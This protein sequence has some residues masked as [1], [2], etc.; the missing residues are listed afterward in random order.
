MVDGE[1]Y[2]YTCICISLALEMDIYYVYLGVDLGM[3]ART[4][5]GRWWSP[6]WNSEGHT[7]LGT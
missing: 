1:G 4:K 3:M 5:V 6:H 7:Y 2:M